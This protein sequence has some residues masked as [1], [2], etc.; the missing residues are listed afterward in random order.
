MSSYKQINNDQKE[1]LYQVDRDDVPEKTFFF[2]S[3]EALEIQFSP[4]LTTNSGLKQLSLKTSESFL[5]L[6]F[7]NHSELRNIN[8]ESFCEVVPLSGALYYSLADAFYNTFNRA[9]PQAFLGVRRHYRDNKWVADISYRNIDSIPVEKEPFL[10]IS[11][12][13]AT[14][15]TLFSLLHEIKKEIEPN[16]IQGIAIFSIAGAL[17]GIRLLKKMEKMFPKTYIYSAN[18]IFGLDDN[19]T[20]MQWLHKDTITTPEIRNKAIENYGP[21]LAQHWCNIWDWGDRG[22]NPLV[23]LRD[24]EEMIIRY[25]Q[26]EDLDTLT[27]EKLKF[28]LNKVQNEIKKMTTPFI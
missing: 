9:I 10:L 22:N 25:Q 15:S 6:L 14:G 7:S 21:F 23:Y 3:P 18:A 28:F 5:R 27:Q 20:D 12:T 24:T 13:I 26:H 4:W 11:D 16:H 2:N 1:K 17:P 8:P 19:G